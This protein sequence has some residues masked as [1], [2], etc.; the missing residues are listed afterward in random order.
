MQTVTQILMRL[1]DVAEAKL[2][3][4]NNADVSA[5][6]KDSVTKLPVEHE[7]FA[8]SHLRQKAKDNRTSESS[9][10]TEI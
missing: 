5:V 1:C 6:A 10:D 8:Q 3:A 9:P 2:N 4:Q 7:P